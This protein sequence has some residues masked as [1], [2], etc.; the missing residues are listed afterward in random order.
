MSINLWTSC[1][2]DSPIIQVN[3]P[4]PIRKSKKIATTFKIKLDI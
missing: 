4:K 2:Y 1:S 3:L